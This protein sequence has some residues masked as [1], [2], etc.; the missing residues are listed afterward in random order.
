MSGAT[1]KVSRPAED[2]SPRACPI[3]LVHLARQTLGDRSLEIELLS[4]FERQA[5]QVLDRIVAE[6]AD[7]KTLADLG[8]TLRGSARAVGATRVAG[9]AMDFETAMTTATPDPAA[10]DAA[11]DELARAVKEARAAIREMLSDR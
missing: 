10:A 2:K 4:L 3:D 6:P 5:G 8:H 9:A 11:R 7:R 1:Q